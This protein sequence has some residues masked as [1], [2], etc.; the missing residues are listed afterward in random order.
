GRATAPKPPMPTSPVAGQAFFGSVKV[1]A[2]APAGAR[3]AVATDSGMRSSCRYTGVVVPVRSGRVGGSVPLA[4]GAHRLT[5]TFCG[6]TTAAPLR[7]GAVTVDDVWVLSSAER[8]ADPPRIESTALNTRLS[9][10]A[11]TFSG[12]SGIYYHDLSTGTTA[13]WNADARFP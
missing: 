3:W 1:A 12:I 9:S 7:L 11:R 2:K 4:P 8:K 6:G 5:V 13:T 10:L